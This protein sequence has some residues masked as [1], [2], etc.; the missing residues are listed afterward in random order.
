MGRNWTQVLHDIL[1]EKV[2]FKNPIEQFIA[3]AK[4]KNLDK[5]T[6]VAIVAVHILLLC[7][8]IKHSVFFPV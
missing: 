2:S 7:V 4:F 3:Y 8:L 1:S 6:L 5:N